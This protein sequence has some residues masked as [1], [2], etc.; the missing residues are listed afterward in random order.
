MLDTFD[1]NKSSRK[2]WSNM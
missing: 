2:Y 1:R